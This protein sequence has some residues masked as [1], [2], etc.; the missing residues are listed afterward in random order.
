MQSLMKLI[1]TVQ[2]AYILLALLL[3]AVAW[4]V[5][6]WLGFGGPVQAGPHTGN[7]GWRAGQTAPTPTPTPVISAGVNWHGAKAW[8]EAGYKGQGIK[9]GIIDT[10]FDGLSGL[11]GKELPTSSSG[12]VNI[13]CYDQQGDHITRVGTLATNLGDLAHC[14]GQYDRKGKQIR[15]NHGTLVAQAIM[16]VAPEVTLYIANPPAGEK[17]QDTVNWMLIQGVDVINRS[18]VSS[19][20]APGDGTSGRGAGTSHSLNLIDRAAGTPVPAGRPKPASTP[21]RALWVNGGGNE[22]ELTWYGAYYNPDE[23]T[24]TDRTMRWLSFRSGTTNDEVNPIRLY[25]GKEVTISMRWQDAWGTAPGVT[26]GAKCDL[27]LYLYRATPTK[28][29]FAAG[30]ASFQR[31]LTHENPYEVISLTLTGAVPASGADYVVVINSYGCI[32]EHRPSWIQ[33]QVLG[34]KVG[35]LSYVT[36]AGNFANSGPDYYQIGVPAESKNEGMLSVGAAQQDR[37]RLV[38]SDSS[39]RGPTIDRMVKPDLVGFNCGLAITKVA[40]VTVSDFCG[41]SAA[42]PHVTGLAALLLQRYSTF[43]DNPVALATHLIG[44]ATQYGDSDPNNAW[45]EGFAYLHRPSGRAS[46]TSTPTVIR[47]PSSTSTGGPPT[48]T[49]RGQDFTVNTNIGKPPGVLV[50]V[51]SHLTLN[52]RCDSRKETSNTYGEKEVVN[53]QGCVA[54]NNAKVWLYDGNKELN[55]YTV[56]VQSNAPPPTNV[57]L[58]TV[59]GQSGHLR[60]TY[61]Q[62]RAPHYYQFQLER[63]DLSASSE[64]WTVVRTNNVR[65][66]QYTF[67]SVAR[68]YQYRVLGRNCSDSARS[69]CGP[70]GSY[71]PVLEFSNPTIAISGLT[72]SYIAGDSD[73]FSVALSDLTLDQ[74]YTVTFLTSNSTIGYNYLCHPIPLQSFTALGR[75]TL[76]LTLHTCQP[77]GN[78][79]AATVTAQLRKGNARGAIVATATANV[80]VAKAT[81]SLSS[82]PAA[83]TVGHDRTLTVTTNVP[84]NPGVWI[85]ATVAGDAGRTTLPPTRGCYS[86]SSGRAAVNGSAITLRG[87]QAGKTTLTLYRSNSVIQLASYTVTVNDSNTNLSPTPSTITAGHDRT[88]TLTTDIANNPGV[89]ITATVAGDAGRTTLPPTRGCHSASSGIAAVN[90]NAITLRGCQAGKTTLTLY[91]SNSSALLKSY[92][93]TVSASA[94]SLSPTPATFAIGTNQTFTVTTDIAN[95]PGLWIGFNY[96]GDTGRLEPA[97]QSCSPSGSGIASVTAVN[98]NSI[99][100]KPCRAGTVTIKVNR[101]YSSVTLVTYEVTINSS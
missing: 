71:S 52:N 36:G 94:T 15:K 17:L 1:G 34:S 21:A 59:S 46:F 58:S 84:N 90:G 28:Y 50:E 44:S 24:E 101:S 23:A 2:P 27:D 95:T 64:T 72:G 81:G 10:G 98:G 42:A 62:S 55:S 82:V 47:I 26:E 54:S 100:L 77:S 25:P 48:Q 66:S 80:T 83:I 3:A 40:P 76:N 79:A 75:K 4:T 97:N 12:K 74:P 8:Q 11:L 93:V 56:R 45:G 49:V 22:A 9:V 87:C 53:L 68:G 43:R 18:V 14:R 41:S 6:I 91:R 39:N 60:L 85:T 99:T 19:L 57:R 37:S 69:N 20:N 16:D 96:P 63:R 7:A 73:A 29:V 78:T 51:S 61:S 88:F 70:W 35:G 65:V 31:G 67:G 5:P 13:R 86:A 32:A 33:L 89:W 38:V 30:S 92:T